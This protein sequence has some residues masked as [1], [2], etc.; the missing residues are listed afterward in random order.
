MVNHILADV[1]KLMP[2]DTHAKAALQLLDPHL[3]LQRTS[4]ESR[5]HV[6][7]PNVDEPQVQLL[8][9]RQVELIQSPFLL[10]S[11]R[12]L[13]PEERALDQQ[14]RFMTDLTQELRTPPNDCE[15]ESATNGSAEQS[16]QGR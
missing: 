15:Q 13:S 6:L 14:Q 9:W 8:R 3:P 16:P 12:D 4:G 2:L 7:S 1:L 11:F 10:V 5:C